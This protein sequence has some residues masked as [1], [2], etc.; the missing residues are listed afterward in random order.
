MSPT[1]HLPLTCPHRPDCIF[2]FSG[3]LVFISSACPHMRDKEGV[4]VRG[5]EVSVFSSKLLGHKGE[6]SAKVWV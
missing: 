6:T 3:I 4:V 1:K 2:Q 5:M